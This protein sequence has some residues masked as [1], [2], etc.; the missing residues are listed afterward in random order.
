MSLQSEFQALLELLGLLLLNGRTG[1]L[2][3]LLLV[4]AVID[5][6]THRIPNGLVL[7]G[8]A[9]SLVFN[10]LH[11]P[12]PGA[13]PLWTLAGAGIGLL[14]LLP[15]YALGVLGAGDVKLMAMVGAFV[16]PAALPP[17]LLY[18]LVCGGL[19]ALAWTVARGTAGRAWRNLRQVAQLAL[20]DTLVGRKASLH[21]DRQ[22]SAGKLPYALA[23]GLGAVCQLLL[24]PLGLLR[25]WTGT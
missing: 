21:I 17:V 20:H 14:S 2:L 22:A 15:L 16:G 5:C 19:L 9:Y 8:L 7:C 18:T 10:A 3:A 1:A 4:A 23:I 13:T 6:R 12:H 25:P 11:P 24:Q